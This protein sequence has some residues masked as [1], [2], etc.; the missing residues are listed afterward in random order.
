[1]MDNFA[2]SLAHVLA[3]EGGKVD[4]PRDPGG[5]T[6]CGITQR[7]YDA[8]RTRHG[9]PP[10]DVWLLDPNE[11]E[12]IYREDYWNKVSGDLLPHGVDYATF[13]FAVN[14]GPHE[15]D[16]CL[17]RA[18]EALQ[19]SAGVTADG[20]IGPVTL[21]ALN[22]ADP[23]RVIHEIC[24]ERLAFMQEHCDWADFGNG[25]S[26]RVASVEITARGMA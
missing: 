22:A 26:K 19:S 2:P 12:A 4:N 25:W 11:R 20:V 17:Q 21:A 23:L 5:R 6:N 14:S 9:Q 10:R 3:S 16:V 7:E 24:A 1:M 8:W 13:D 18:I 15:A